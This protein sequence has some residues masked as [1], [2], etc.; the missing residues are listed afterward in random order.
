MA[1]KTRDKVLSRTVSDPPA[2]HFGF[3]FFGGGAF[4]IVLRASSS[5][6]GGCWPFGFSGFLAI[7]HLVYIDDSYERPC[8]TF[9]GI[10]IPAAAWQSTFRAIREWRQSLKRSDGIMVTRELHATEFVAGRGRLGPQI[11]TKHRRSQIFHGAF[12]MMNRL[13]TVRVFTSCRFD[14]QE[15]CFE[16]LVNRINRTMEAWDSH[17]MLICDEGKEAEYTRLIRKMGV[18]NPIGSR[19]GVWLDTGEA[20]KNLPIT[21]ILE[22][23]FF[24]QSDRSYFV[25]LAD[26]V[27]YGLLRR[28]KHLASKNRYGLHRSFD[29]LQNVVVR[30]CNPRDPMGVI[31]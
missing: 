5:S 2:S 20:S 27:A 17:A 3:S 31:R 4:S 12:R 26:F 6:F 29:E 30:A 19:Y 16:R 11:V 21:R 9:A 15:W 1:K 23:P 24:K 25:Q 13:D 8:A 10:A 18:Y 22:D 28:E 7:M 14:H